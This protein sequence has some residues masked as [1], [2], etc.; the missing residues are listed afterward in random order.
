[1]IDLGAKLQLLT[2]HLGECG[3]TES[4]GRHVGPAEIDVVVAGLEAKVNIQVQFFALK[5]FGFQLFVIEL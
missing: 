3:L 4:E 2:N 1:L 5:L